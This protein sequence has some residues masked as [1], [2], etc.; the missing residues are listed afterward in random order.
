[1]QTALNNVGNTQSLSE[2][3]IANFEIAL[4]SAQKDLEI[5]KSNLIIVENEEKQKY[6]NKLEDAITT[7]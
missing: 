1:L 4:N 7:I 3:D 5:A 6:E 2:N